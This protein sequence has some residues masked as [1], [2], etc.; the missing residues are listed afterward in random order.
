MPGF[1]HKNS[2]F[3]N[4]EF[5]M[6]FYCYFVL[7]FIMFSTFQSLCFRFIVKIFTLQLF[8]AI[9]EKL[10]SQVHNRWTQ[11]KVI[12]FDMFVA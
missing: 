3:M 11:K 8:I 12:I 9:F 1:L 10:P 7:I 2:S 6:A 5:V 4:T